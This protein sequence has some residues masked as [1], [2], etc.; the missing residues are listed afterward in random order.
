MMDAAL[1][2]VLWRF[3]CF[4]VGTAIGFGWGFSAGLHQAARVLRDIREGLKR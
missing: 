2:E 1:V 3:A 4:V